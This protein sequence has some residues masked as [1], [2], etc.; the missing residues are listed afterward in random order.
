MNN[1]IYTVGLF[2]FVER[3]ALKPFR[4]PFPEFSQPGFSILTKGVID[5]K[6]YFVTMCINTK[7]T[8]ITILY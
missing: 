7:S 6:V 2:M 8:I 4:N 5:I 1:C 3:T